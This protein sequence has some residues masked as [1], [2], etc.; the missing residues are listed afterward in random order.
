MRLVIVV[1]KISCYNHTYFLVI[2]SPRYVGNYSPRQGGE[3]N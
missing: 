1:E 2:D 3:M